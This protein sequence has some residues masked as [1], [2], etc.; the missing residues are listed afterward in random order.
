[1]VGFATKSNQRGGYKPKRHGILPAQR[2][3][4][5][6]IMLRAILARPVAV[7][8]H[9]REHES[10]SGGEGEGRKR[11]TKARRRKPLDSLLNH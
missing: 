8:A 7:P 5:E 6:G 1:M 11:I 2:R 10:E 3:D 9:A 4:G